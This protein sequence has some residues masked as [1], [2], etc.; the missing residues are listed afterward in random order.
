MKAFKVH[1]VFAGSVAALTS[2]TACCWP[3]HSHIIFVSLPYRVKVNYSTEHPP[4]SSETTLGT[5]AHVLLRVV[6]PP[7]SHIGL[8][9]AICQRESMQWKPALPGIMKAVMDY[10][11]LRNTMSWPTVAATLL[12]KQLSSYYK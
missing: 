9:T 2:S 1:E 8:T 3:L 12:R 7:I 6:S 11:S 10:L 5:S 4:V